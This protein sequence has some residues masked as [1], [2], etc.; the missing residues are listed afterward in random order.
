MFK[1]NKCPSIYLEL[2]IVVFNLLKDLG[3]QKRRHSISLTSQEE[4]KSLF[5]ALF[6][7]LH[8]FVK[9][10]DLELAEEKE[11]LKYL[12]DLAHNTSIIF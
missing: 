7:F 6:T 11:I 1:N 8:N 10:I 2:L 5:S 12:L 3:T 9:N 4:I